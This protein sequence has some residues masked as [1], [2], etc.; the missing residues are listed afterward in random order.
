M[1][2]FSREININQQGVRSLFGCLCVDVSQENACNLVIF[3]ARKILLYFFLHRI[4]WG[5]QWYHQILSLVT[6]LLRKRTKAKCNMLRNCENFLKNKSLISQSFWTWL[7]KVRGVLELS[8]P[9]LSKTPLTF[10]EMHFKGLKTPKSKCNKISETPCLYLNTCRFFVNLRHCCTC[11]WM[12]SRGILYN[13]ILQRCMSVCRGWRCCRVGRGGGAFSHRSRYRHSSHYTELQHGGAKWGS[14]SCSAGSHTQLS[15]LVSTKS[16]LWS[17][18]S[19][20]MKYF[21]DRLRALEGFL[22]ICV[23]YSLNMFI[24]IRLTNELYKA[25][26]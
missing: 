17:N 24:A 6:A 5:I 26:N 9:Q 1:T 15:V 14:V 10:L 2:L 8:C 4:Q 3:S 23:E 18:P 20:E 19:R 11:M 25:G 16:A 12:I 7:R 13:S 22:F 21:S